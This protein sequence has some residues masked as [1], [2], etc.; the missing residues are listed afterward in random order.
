V[1]DP[2]ISSVLRVAL[3]LSP[4]QRA[5]LAASLLAGI[6]DGPSAAQ[7]PGG[8]PMAARLW[9]LEVDFRIDDASDRGEQD[10]PWEHLRGT[11][12]VVGPQVRVV[13]RAEA[14]LRAA[15]ELYQRTR[16]L[17]VALLVESLEET[18][19]RIRR[20]GDTMPRAPLTNP[21]R[22]VRQATVHGFPLQLLF[23]DDKQGDLRILAL[24]RVGR[25]PAA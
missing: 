14:E 5:D 4:A 2:T 1:S 16:P 24:V 18:V 12:P 21:L 25:P 6:D 13:P 19:S 22:R 8:A 15:F 11:L 20:E 23:D 3:A 7:A 10:P 17:L 9:A